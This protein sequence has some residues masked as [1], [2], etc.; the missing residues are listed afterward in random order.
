MQSLNSLDLILA[1]RTLIQ[2]TPLIL[3]SPED[4]LYFRSS[5]KAPAKITTPPPL[6]VIPIAEV[7]TT[8]PPIVETK[9]TPPPVVEIKITPPL[10]QPTPKAPTVWITEPI[11]K[12]AEK[13]VSGFSQLPRLFQKIAPHI[14]IL[15]DIPNDTNAK[16]IAT[17]WKTR[18]QIAPISIL[19][20]H[21]PQ[22]Q[23]EL[24][25]EI[26]KAID[27][28]FGPA[29]LIEADAIEKEK[30]WDTFLA[31]PSLKCVV[32]CDYTLWQ[33][34]DLMRFYKEKSSEQTRTLGNIPLFLLPDLSLYLKDPLLKK[35]LWKGICHKFS[36]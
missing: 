36:S 35:S 30:Q 16:K 3:A 9:I 31:D 21:E 24:L 19:S 10:P 2:E 29:R 32:A 22:K 17:R 26:S 20:F 6:P 8:P 27:V 4:A 18:N 7:K 12:P 11:P 23:K 25:L 14:S 5:I 33:L 28:Y 1:L 34:G 13:N 15:S